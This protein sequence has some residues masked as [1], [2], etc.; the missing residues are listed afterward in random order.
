MSFHRA[1]QKKAI[2]VSKIEIILHVENFKFWAGNREC[3]IATFLKESLF[4]IDDFS[5]FW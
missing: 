3:G 1:I 4:G 2:L 5:R